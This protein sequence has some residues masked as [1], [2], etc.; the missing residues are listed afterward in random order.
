MQIGVTPT[1]KKGSHKA[2]SEQKKA[3]QDEL[4]ALSYKE[5]AGKKRC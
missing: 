1:N 4:E 5:A 2:L 3:L